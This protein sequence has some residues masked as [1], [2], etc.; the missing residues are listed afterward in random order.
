MRTIDLN[1][2]RLPYTYKEIVESNH[3]EFWSAATE[4]IN[5]VYV[6][7]QMI[8]ELLPD[9]KTIIHHYSNKRNSGN[10][11]IALLNYLKLRSIYGFAHFI[12]EQV[13]HKCHD[14]GVSSNNNVQNDIDQAQTKLISLFESFEKVDVFDISQDEKAGFEK[15]E[16]A[17]A[18]FGTKTDFPVISS[19]SF[20]DIVETIKNVNPW[21]DYFWELVLN[22]SIPAAPNV[23]GLMESEDDNKLVRMY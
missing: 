3:P 15:L 23:G 20:L 2:K 8:V 17:V 21:P 5:H 1:G 10:S 12:W 16:Q 13:N 22:D 4:C 6:W 14:L 18:G 9:W 11:P 7:Q 19:F